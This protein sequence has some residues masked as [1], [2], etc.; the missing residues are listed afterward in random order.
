MDA[1]QQ[2]SWR[3]GEQQSEGL[4]QGLANVPIWQFA[5]ILLPLTIAFLIFIFLEYRAQVGMGH[6]RLLTHEAAVIQEGARGVESGLA[7]ATSDL[8]YVVELV[9]VAIEDDTPERFAELQRSTLAFLRNRPGY[10]QIRFID[11]AGRERLRIEDTPN[12]PRVTPEGELQDKSGRSYFSETMRL[13]S[14]E[15]FV[16]PMESNLEKGVEEPHR[17][18]VRLAT[19]IDSAAGA[20]RGIVILNA[21]GAYFMRAFEHG[22]DDTGAQRSIVDSGGDWVEQQRDAE[23]SAES[24]RGRSFQQAF[25]EIWIQAL[26]K[27]RGWM[28]NSEGLFYVDS[29]TPPAAAS[30]PSGK[31]RE[32]PAWMYISFLPRRLLDDLAIEVATPLLVIATP[33]YFGLMLIG[34]LLA[35]A[36][37][38][39]KLA[40]QEMRDLEQLKRAMLTA[41]LDAIVVMD[42]KGRTLEFNPAAQEI[43]GYTLEEARGQLVADL[44]IPPQDREKH[45]LG[46]E[47]YLETGEGH[48][49]GKRVTEICGIRKSGE[50]F[51]VELTICPVMVTGKHFF[52][53]FLRDLSEFDRKETET[54]SP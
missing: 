12:G 28:E 20:R 32:L 16:S 25:P 37:H 19:P 30:N 40:D 26:A 3:E 43:F 1:R 13:Q 53:G 29:V 44:I 14:G 10:F 50:E 4:F 48:I 54:P 8:S 7:I 52:Y 34:S 36:I 51:P 39:R 33:T 27:S 11:A 2:Q 18:V 35:S 23:W 21:H 42:E 22:S 9:A 15:L 5:K 6:A 46:L 24:G 49:I 31:G 17:P 45:R 38:R 41:A 47:Y